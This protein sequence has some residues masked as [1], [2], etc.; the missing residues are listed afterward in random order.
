MTNKPNKQEGEKV[1]I[2]DVA[3]G[4]AIIS[5]AG[6]GDWQKK[7]RRLWEILKIA[8]PKKQEMPRYTYSLYYYVENG[9][10]YE[11]TWRDGNA[12][13]VLEIID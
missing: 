2:K 3:E 9:R 13:P 12:V 5:M 7:V 1:T 4:R 11:S 6:K 8:S 10:W